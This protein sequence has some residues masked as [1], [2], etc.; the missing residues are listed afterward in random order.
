MQGCDKAGAGVCVCVCVGG[1]GGGAGDR[2]KGL[3][4]YNGLWDIGGASHWGVGGGKERKGQ[5]TVEGWSGLIGWER[6]RH[7]CEWNNEIGVHVIQN[8]QTE[9]IHLML[10][11]GSNF[12]ENAHWSYYT[13]D[14]ANEVKHWRGEGL[15]LVFGI[16]FF[17]T[18]HAFILSRRIQ[19]EQTDVSF[20]K[21]KKLIKNK[22][23]RVRHLSTQV[24][25]AIN[26]ATQFMWII[27]YTSVISCS[28]L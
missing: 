7:V 27:N 21:K 28:P 11:P 23:K 13:L 4:G 16:T 20:K 6:G 22:N 10:L 18:T 26:R 14:P 24:V 9:I 8:V 12:S 15:K 19:T 1:R 17:V 3:R 5:C 25:A 2:G